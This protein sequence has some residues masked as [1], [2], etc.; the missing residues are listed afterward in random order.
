MKVGDAIANI[1]EEWIKCISPANLR[2]GRIIV[3]PELTTREVAGMMDVTLWTVRKWIQDGKLKAYQVGK[4]GVWRIG[5][6]DFASFRKESVE[7]SMERYN[8][9]RKMSTD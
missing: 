2:S 5:I 3:A 1:S 4:W 8:Q 7:E 6:D 9:Y